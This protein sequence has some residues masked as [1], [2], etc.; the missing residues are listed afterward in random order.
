MEQN[1]YIYIFNFGDY[2]ARLTAKKIRDLGG[3]PRIVSF[4][5]PFSHLK[6]PAGFILSGSPNSSF[7]IPVRFLNREVFAANHPVLGICV[8]AHLMTRYFGGKYKNLKKRAENGVVKLYIGR[9]NKIFRDLNSVEEV[10]MMHQDSI[11]DPGGGFRV[12][13]RTDRCPIAATSNKKWRWYTLQFHPE[14]SPCG[15]K[16]FKNFLQLCYKERTELKPKK[17]ETVSHISGKETIKPHLPEYAN[18]ANGSIN[19]NL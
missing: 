12:I 14:L 3:K 4:N 1:K 2:F 15:T 19:V 13:A 8:G 7:R 10:L 16:I 5:T 11:T 9:K 17:S 6:K 18:N